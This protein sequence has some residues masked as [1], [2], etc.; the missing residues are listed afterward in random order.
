MKEKT[1]K[2]IALENHMLLSKIEAALLKN[3]EKALVIEKIIIS[4]RNNKTG[5]IPNIRRLN[6]IE[7]KGK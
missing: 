3:G 7:L 6:E 5:N 4:I 1:W 2:E